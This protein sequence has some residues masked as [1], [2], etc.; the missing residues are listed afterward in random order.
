[1]CDIVVGRGVI[2][3]FC[4]EGEV[5]RSVGI[6]VSVGYF[7]CEVV[8]GDGWFICNSFFLLGCLFVFRVWAASI[9]IR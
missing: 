5:V 1:M 8:G 9:S 3:C 4:L 6:R 7:L 2:R